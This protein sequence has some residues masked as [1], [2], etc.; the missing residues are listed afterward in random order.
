[1]RSDS[2]DSLISKR[3]ARICSSNNI[4]ATL[5][6]R[7]FYVQGRQHAVTTYFTEEPQVDYMEA[8]LQTLFQIHVEQPPGDVLV[9]LPGWW[10][11]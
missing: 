7:I 1:M 11:R 4:S 3:F 8:A 2:A 5:S 6:A 10:Q 9:F